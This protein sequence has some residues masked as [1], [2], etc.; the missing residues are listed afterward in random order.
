[1]TEKQWLIFQFKTTHEA[2]FALNHYLLACGAAGISTID[3]T[4][5]LES[6]QTNYSPDVIAEDFLNSLD[7]EVMIEAYFPVY[8]GLS[9]PDDKFYP[10]NKR[11][12]RSEENLKVEINQD[13]NS[14]VTE[15][16]VPKTAK[17]RISIAQFEKIIEQSLTRIAEFSDI[18][19]GYV[20]YRQLAEENWSENW[21][22]YYRTH[23]IGRIVINPSWLEY[24]VQADEILLNLDPGSAFG[25]GEHESTSSVLRFLSDFDFSVLPTGPI[26]DLG[27]GSGILAIAL[28]KIL[29]DSEIIALD[30]DPHAVEVAKKNAAFN[31][32][33]NIDFVTGELHSQNQKYGLII[34]NLTASIH[35]DLI[36]E[37]MRKLISGGYLMLSGIINQRADEVRTVFAQNGFVPVSEIDDNDWLSIVYR[38]DTK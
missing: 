33:E 13:L 10:D 24:S 6:F 20:G 32:V 28:A 11:S 27:T 37:Y 34:A 17:Q 30:I 12:L 7:Y 26:L 23:K 8:T 2:A 16:E 18:G 4:E 35:L 14:A 9:A 22:K 21:K 1:M 5:L 3:K 19:Q 31:F 25:T 29:P 38:I 15:T 36:Q